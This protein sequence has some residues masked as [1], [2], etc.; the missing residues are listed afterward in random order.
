MIRLVLF[1]LLYAIP[2][3]IVSWLVLLIV[4]HIDQ[5]SLVMLVT[6]IVV[7][8]M[9]W[10][11]RWGNRKAVAEGKEPEKMSWIVMGVLVVASLAA[12]A[13]MFESNKADLYIANGTDKAVK[14]ELDHEGS[15]LITP[16]GYQ[17]VQVVKGENRGHYTGGDRKF[18]INSGGNWVWNIDSAETFVLTAISYAS[19]EQLYRNKKDIESKEEENPDF[20]VIRSEFFETP[21]D[22]MFEA[23]KTI[24]VKKSD[25]SKEVKKKVLYR[26]S[27]LL[28]E[29]GNED[30]AES[31]KPAEEGKMV[32][33]DTAVVK[34]TSNKEKKNK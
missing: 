33:N 25:F 32:E 34:F 26:W 12:S 24:T 28:D 20:K 5:T 2:A 19:E 13:M 16:H 6:G 22:Y 10:F 7:S 14:V 23:P 30:M 31:E 4:P 3:A 15:F 21:A 29:A 9:V 8:G 18:N 1:L 17:K 27:D 11:H